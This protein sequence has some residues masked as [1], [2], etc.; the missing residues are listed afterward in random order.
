MVCILDNDGG[1]ATSWG[2]AQRKRLGMLWTKGITTSF[3]TS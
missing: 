3:I 1:E 2:Q